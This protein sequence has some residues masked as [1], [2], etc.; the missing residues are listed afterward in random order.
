MRDFL[1]EKLD[2]HMHKH[3]ELEHHND[4]A[5]PTFQFRTVRTFRSALTRQIAEA[6]RIRRRGTDVI[7][8]KG[9]YNRCVLPRLVIE[10]D[11]KK[12]QLEQL[13]QHNREQLPPDDLENEWMRTA[14]RRTRRREQDEDELVT[15][16]RMRRDDHEFEDWGCRPIFVARTVSKQVPPTPSAQPKTMKQTLLRLLSEPEVMAKYI[17]AIVLERTGCLTELSC[18]EA[19]AEEAIISEEFSKVESG[20]SVLVESMVD[21]AVARA[22]QNQRQSEL[23]LVLSYG[24]SKAV[25]TRKH[26]RKPTNQPT[27]RSMWVQDR[28]VDQ[29][30]QQ[31]N[32][33]KNKALAEARLRKTVQK[34]SVSQIM[35]EV[36]GWAV[37]RAEQIRKESGADRILA[38]IVNRACVRAELRAAQKRICGVA[39]IPKPRLIQPKMSEIWGIRA[40][41]QNTDQKS[42]STLISNLSSSIKG[43]TKEFNSQPEVKPNKRKNENCKTSIQLSKKRKILPKQPSLVYQGGWGGGENKR[44]WGEIM[45]KFEDNRSKR[46][47]REVKSK[48][49]I[50]S[51]YTTTGRENSDLSGVYKGL[52]EEGMLS[53]FSSAASQSS[54]QEQE[55]V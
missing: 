29:A 43:P 3:S 33:V 15:S 20:A 36:M 38:N 18:E 46:S 7:N 39:R 41:M 9:V 31:R 13:D 12:N 30:E 42:R 40:S 44:K 51:N 52:M 47:R 2:S 21:C 48:S 49:V 27:I 34:R 45:P 1:A 4:V 14:A 35:S 37:D 23:N 55:I 6:V 22:E 54:D 11:V 53:T 25:A 28:G 19:L 26:E 17:I 16:K 24:I 8:S 50:R 5:K 10:Q 32:S